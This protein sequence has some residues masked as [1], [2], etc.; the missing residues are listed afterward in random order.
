MLVESI[1]LAIEQNKTPSKA[2]IAAVVTVILY[3]FALFSVYHRNEQ[4]ELLKMSSNLEKHVKNQ[5][6][7][8]QQGLI[9]ETS[10]PISLIDQA[11]CNEM[12]AAISSGNMQIRNRNKRSSENVH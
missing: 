6:L 2:F 10:K 1:E 8:K 12:S 9:N 3:F 11:Q 7:K 5:D 4:Y